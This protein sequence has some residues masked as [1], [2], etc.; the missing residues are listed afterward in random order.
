M[1][2]FILDITK[3]EL[4]QELALKGI[5]DTRVLNAIAKIPRENFVHPA[6][7]KS[8]YKDVALPI[9]AHQTISQPFTVAYMTQLL[10]VQPGMKVL[11]IG[12]GSGY[13][14][15]VLAELGAY[16]TSVERQPELYTKTTTLLHE[17]GYKIITIL[18]DGTQGYPPHAPYDRIIITAGAP[19]IPKTLLTQL[20]VGGKMILPVGDAKQQQ[21]QLITCN[22]HNDYDV[23]VVKENFSFVPLI[24][25]HGWNG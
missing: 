24:G 1:A 20:K 11:E 3:E 25:E 19:D 17:L 14:A 13:Q 12:T 9:G 7:V 15:A 16:V 23:F 5:T 22:A 21:M 8:S 4:L 10:D 2:K 6:F 18:G